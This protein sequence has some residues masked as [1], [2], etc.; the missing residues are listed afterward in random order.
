MDRMVAQP[1]WRHVRPALYA[2]EGR[3]FPEIGWPA[4]N[5]SDML[6]TT[7]VEGPLFRTAL[8]FLKGLGHPLHQAL[9][10]MVTA[11][12]AHDDP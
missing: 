6:S 2:F 12:L 7:D 1:D 4:T 8:A 11:L 10:H 9:G 5:P 3:S